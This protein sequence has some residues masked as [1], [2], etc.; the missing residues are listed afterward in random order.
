MNVEKACKKLGK[1]YFE[2]AVYGHK[3]GNAIFECSVKHGEP[4]FWC[5]VAMHALDQ[6]KDLKGY[7]I[8]EALIDFLINISLMEKIPL[9]RMANWIEQVDEQLKQHP[10]YLKKLKPED[11]GIQNGI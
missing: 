8:G 6:V 9:S 4:D 3:E 2:V 10:E 5:N 1:E 11:E 7:T